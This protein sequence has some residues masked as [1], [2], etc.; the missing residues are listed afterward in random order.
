M[1]VIAGSTGNTGSVVT[2]TLLAKGHKV[3]LLVRDPKKV[4]HFVSRGAEV[5]VAP[6]HDVAALTSALGG[7]RG[8]YLLIPA[9]EHMPD[10]LAEHSQL[11]AAIAAALRA[12][13]PAH[14]VLLS[15]VGAQHADGTGP[16]RGLHEAE[17]VLAQAQP[18]ITFVRA[19]YFMENFAQEL[20]GVP[21]GVFPTL[22]QP[23]VEVPM[24]STR[25][26]G[27]TA[28]NALLEGGR[29]RQVIELE[30]PRRYTSADACAEVARQ[31]GKPLALQVVPEAAIAATLEGFGMQPK[32]AAL[33]AEMLRGIHSGHVSLEG[34][35]ARHVRGVTTLADVLSK[36]LQ[37]PARG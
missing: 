34:S 32:T 6:L 17:R 33:Y 35:V 14:V 20:A 4:E 37:R 10:M 36:L 1:F 12:S 9:S 18:D 8:V 31:L 3:R 16:I 2:E 25:D 30:G 22:L 23:E 19:S 11:I 21:N 15:S 28:A 24:V 27:T 7:A 5:A 29:G 26:I 13:K